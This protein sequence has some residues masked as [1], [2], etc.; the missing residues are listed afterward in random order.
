MLFEDAARGGF[1]NFARPVFIRKTLA[2]MIAPCLPASADMTAKIVTGRPAK[3]G[4]KDR[5][6][7]GRDRWEFAGPVKSAN[8]RRGD[9]REKEKAARRRP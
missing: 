3:V 1:K 9:D 6:I 2:E 7:M 4:L 5:F 8:G